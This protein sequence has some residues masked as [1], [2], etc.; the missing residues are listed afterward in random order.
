MVSGIQ[1]EPPPSAVPPFPVLMAGNLRPAGVTVYACQLWASAS[2]EW[3][4]DAVR[5]HD[6]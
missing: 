3:H 4:A 5:A 6:P 1:G 2:S